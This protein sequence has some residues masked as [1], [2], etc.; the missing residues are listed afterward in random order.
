MEDFCYGFAMDSRR[1]LHPI[2]PSGALRAWHRTYLFRSLHSNN[3]GS[4]TPP[5]SLTILREELRQSRKNSEAMEILEM[6]V[7]WKV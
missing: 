1:G 6:F 2:R 7:L 5:Y 3:A 4:T